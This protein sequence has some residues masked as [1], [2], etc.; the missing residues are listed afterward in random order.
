M[1]KPVLPPLYHLAKRLLILVEQ[2]VRHFE[3]YHKYTIGSDLRRQAMQIMRKIHRATYNRNLENVS[4]LLYEIEEFKITLQLAK[5][6]KAFKSLL[7]FNEIADL[8]VEMGKQCGG[9]HRAIKHQ[10]K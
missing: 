1:A 3:R 9:W 6:I 5:D 7:Q 2:K 10:A 4:K 8:A